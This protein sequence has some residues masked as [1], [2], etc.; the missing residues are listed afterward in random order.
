VPHKESQQIPASQV[1]ASANRLSRLAKSPDGHLEAA[2]RDGKFEAESQHVRKDGTRYWAHVTI[3]PVYD[4]DGCL[5]GFAKILRDMTEFRE[6]RGQLKKTEEQLFEAQK[7][8]AVGQLAG[9]IAH[10]FNNI[11]SVIIGNVDLL[12]DDKTL[13]QTAKR[14]VQLIVKAARRGTDLTQDLLALSQAEPSDM[15]TDNIKAIVPN[16][17]MCVSTGPK[18]TSTGAIVGASSQRVTERFLE[19]LVPREN[20]SAHVI[21]SG[22]ELSSVFDDVF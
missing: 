21:G 2:I 4:E 1:A 11:L 12:R 9:G 7:L 17:L 10:D 22:C 5:V 6:A 14:A 18:T 16:A 15:C 13:P 3:D 20:S 19:V 8:E